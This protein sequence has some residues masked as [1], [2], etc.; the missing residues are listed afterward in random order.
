MLMFKRTTTLRILLEADDNIGM[1]PAVILT[2]DQNEG[3]S[4]FHDV[5]A[6]LKG[7]HRCGESSCD[8]TS[9]VRIVEAS[10]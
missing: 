9:L 2:L 5:G 6:A 10:M 4:R 3:N 8:M 1:H 7:I